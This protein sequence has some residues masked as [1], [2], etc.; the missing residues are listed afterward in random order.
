MN[1]SSDILLGKYQLL[2]RLGTSGLATVYRAR[3]TSTNDTLTLK[4]LRA[5]FFREADLLIKF[6]STVSQVKELNHTNIV[7]VHGIERD[8]EL[9]AVVM[10]YV[11]WPN[12]K[13]R[14]RV[15]LPLNEVARILHQ[16]GAALE[17]AH[18]RGIVHRDLRPSN[19]FY[20]PGSGRVMVSDFGIITLV[21]GGHVLLRSTVNTPAPSYAAPEQIQGHPAHPSNDVYAM[22]ALGYELLT[23]TVPFDALSPYSILSRQLTITPASPSYLTDSLPQEVDDVVLK[24]LKPNPEERYASCGEFAEALSRVA[25]HYAVREPVAVGPSALH[26]PSVEAEATER[27]DAREIEDGR[28]FCTHCG[29]GNSATASRCYKCWG[30]LVTQ[31]VMTRDEEE[32]RIARYLAII[33]RRKRLIW[34]TVTATATVLLALWIFNLFDLRPPLPDPTTNISS[35]AAAGEWSTLQRDLLHT[36]AVPGP[37]FTPTGTVKWSFQS[38]GPIFAVPAVS[39]DKV[40]V[41]TSDRRIVALDKA[42][43][44]VDWT[45]PVNGPVNSSPSVAGGLVFVGLRDGTL[46]ALD[47]DTGILVWRYRTG[48]AIYGSATVIDGSAYI[49]SADYSIYSLDAQTGELR[50]QR[51]TDHGVHA[52]P[53]VDQGIVVVGSQDG[54]LYMVDI[55]NGTLRYQVD[56]T[57][58]IDSTATIVDGVAYLIN[59]SGRVMAFDYTEKDVPFRKGIKRIQLHLFV[60]NMLSTPPRTPGLIWTNRLR[61]Q[62]LGNLAIADG[63]V[64]VSTLPGKLRALD[65]NTGKILWTLEDLPR[66][67]TSPIVSGDTVIQTASDGTVFGFDVATGEE[68]WTVFLDEPLT[69]SPIIA[70]GVLYVPTAHGNLI[71]LE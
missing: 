21:E 16:V 23:G 5:Y 12:L 20:D 1:D 35:Q 56:L 44:D 70:D 59:R 27:V 66:L 9:A 36:G 71:A 18:A 19:V 58:A 42:T 8:G 40:F 54:E 11:P 50:W 4:V 3:D 53:T 30:F 31:P 57:S 24:A 39:G 10:D 29:S 17:Y 7:P 38:E 22:G 33:R 25:S 55:S 68:K 61:E 69:T 51:K 26:A 37:A 48:G 2:D 34:G 41:A 63:R 6:T 49:G 14:D 64:F 67:F 46:L 65:K 15:K 60:W 47:A 52:P 62:S 45:Y 32:Q 13:A 43:G 28:V